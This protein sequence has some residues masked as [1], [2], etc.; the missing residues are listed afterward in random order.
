M[1]NS[2]YLLTSYR[3]Q[4]QPFYTNEADTIQWASGKDG[5]TIKD[6]S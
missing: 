6:T 4:R 2:T 5:F 1:G 3:G